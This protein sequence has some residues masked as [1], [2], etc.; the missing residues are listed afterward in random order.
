MSFTDNIKNHLS[1]YK[2]KYFPT[3][4]NGIWKNNKKSYSHILPES[5]QFDNLLNPYKEE[6]QNYMLDSK[7]KLHT[8]FHHLNSSQAM[9]FNFFFPLY[10]EHKLELIMEFLGFKDELVNYGSVCF[11]KDGLE[12]KF[13]SRQPTK[14]DFF[15]ETVS[16]KKIYFE[17]KYTEGE[18]GREKLDLNKFEK[19]YSKFISTINTKFQ[20]AESFFNNYQILRNIIHI[21]ENSF[22]VFVYPKD[23]NN[24]RKSAEKVTTEFLIPKFHNHFFNVHWNDLFNRISQ[25]N[26]NEKLTIQFNEFKEK[27]LPEIKPS[28]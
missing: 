20:K 15:F 7:I 16:N 26:N 13:G 17:I 27:Y 4:E 28:C 23:N 21:D 2:E 11:E 22:V 18:F 5:N 19:Y 1:N 12:I 6:F 8:D 25:Q 10:K 24:I 14:F 3:L 9:C